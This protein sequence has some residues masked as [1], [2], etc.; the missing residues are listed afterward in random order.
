MPISMKYLFYCEKCG[1]K[2]VYLIGDSI[3]PFDMIKKCPKCNTVM[4]YKLCEEDCQQKDIFTKIIDS[5]KKVF[6]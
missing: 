5:L 4:K 6:D 1:Y 3:T 2:K